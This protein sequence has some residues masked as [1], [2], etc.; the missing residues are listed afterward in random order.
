LGLDI[1]A[2]P[3]CRFYAEDWELSTVSI[4]RGSDIQVNVIRPN[5]I[6]PASS[7]KATVLSAVHDWQREIVT[8]LRSAGVHAVEWQESYSVQYRTDKP[9]DDGINALRIA[10]AYSACGM[11]P[12]PPTLP[13]DVNS[14]P[15]V[16]RHFNYEGDNLVQ[17][18]ELL[19]E[20]QAWIPVEFRGAMMTPNMP[21]GAKY[22]IGSV[23]P[24][25][26]A[27]DQINGRIWQAD[28]TEVA[29]WLRRGPLGR[30]RFDVVTK[31][32]VAE[33]EVSDDGL[34]FVEH[35]AQFGFATMF[36]LAE[37]AKMHRMPMI[38]DI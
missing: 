37:W 13:E 9:A 34:S 10:A 5:P 26:N 27:L 1:Y 17:N 14:D 31:H 19:I 32:I 3:L 25:C 7:D 24:L 36:D 2:G 8:A 16:S 11:W 29:R 12:P 21:N 18:I 20:Y 15:C 6:F 30:G 23:D 4:L 28:A 22:F 38:V 35:M 33:T